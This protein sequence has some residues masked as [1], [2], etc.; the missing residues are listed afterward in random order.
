[1]VRIS[2][3]PPPGFGGDEINSAL[4]DAAKYRFTKE[5]IDKA[6]SAERERCAKIADQWAV[7][8]ADPR[9]AVRIA[10]EIRKL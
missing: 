7:R 2:Q 3:Q 8:V 10:E 1:M 6:V 4:R 9:D 5:D